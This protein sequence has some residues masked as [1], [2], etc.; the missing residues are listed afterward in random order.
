MTRRLEKILCVDDEDDILEIINLCLGDL[1]NMKVL[2]LND[3][4]RALYEVSSFAPDLILLDVMMPKI[5]GVDAIRKFRQ[6]KGLEHTPIVLI[7]ARVQAK[8]IGEYLA[9]G[10]TSVIAKPFDPMALTD[11]VLKIWDESYAA[12]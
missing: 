2:C 7:T 1:G 10:A 4:E 6:I 12:V 5:S 3:I 11:Q 8:E 9:N